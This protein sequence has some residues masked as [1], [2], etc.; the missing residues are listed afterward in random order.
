MLKALKSKCGNWLTYKLKSSKVKK[1]LYRIA[2]IAIVGFMALTNITIPTHAAMVTIAEETDFSD[3]QH[4]YAMT[5]PIEDGTRYSFYTGGW[6][7][8]KANGDP[9]FCIEPWK[10][11]SHGTTVSEKELRIM[12]SGSLSKTLSQIGYFG[13]WSTDRTRADYVTTQMMIWEARGWTVTQKPWYYDQKKAAIEEKIARSA[14]TLSFSGANETVKVNETVSFTDTNGVLSDYM[15]AAGYPNQNTAYTKDGVTLKWNGNT[16]YLT[17]TVN[18]SDTFELRVWN[19][20]EQYTGTPIVY[21]NGNVQLTSPLRKVYDP[22]RSTL[23]LNIQKFGKARIVKHD[24]ITGKVVKKAG[25]VYDI[26][27]ASDESLVSTVTSNEDGIAETGQIPFDQYYYVERTAPDKYLVNKERHYFTV[28]A[29][30]DDS[31]PLEVTASDIPVKGN[32]TIRKE[33]PV[34]GTRPQGDAKLDGAIYGLYADENIMDPSNDGTILY[35]KD[36]EVARRTIVNGCASVEDL[37]LGAYYWKEIEAPVG[38]N[39][40]P[41]KHPVNLRYKDQSTAIVQADTVSKDTVKEQAFQIIKLETPGHG[42]APTLGGAGFVYILKRYVEEY[43]LEEAIKIAKLNDGRI[44]PSEWGYMET[45]DDGYAISKLLPYGK[46]V[47]HESVVPKDHY[48]VDD[49]EVTINEHSPDQPQKFR[50]LID[51]TLET[52]LMIVKKDAESGETVPVSG[53]KFKVKCLTKTADFNAGDYVSYKS[54]WP[55][56]HVVDEW[57]T[58]E[59]G[60][61]MLEMSLK[62]GTYQIEE[63]DAKA[64]Y[65]LNQEPLIFT[66]TEGWSQIVGPDDET[67]IT[68]VEFANTSVKGQAKIDKQGELFKGYESTMTEYG[69][70]FTP[71]YERGMLPNVK[72]VLKAE[73]DIVGVDGTVWYTAG[74]LIETLITDGENITVSSLLPLGSEDHNLYSLRE[75]ETEEGYALDDTV[76]YFR[77]DYVDQN[78]PVVSPT[79]VNEN[80]DPIVFSGT[81][82]NDKQTGLAIANKEL[83]ESETNDT[84][85]AYKNVVFGL[86]TDDVDGL[87]TGSLVGI[88]TVNEDKKVEISM[89]REGSYYMQELKTDPLY[90]LDT[91]KYPLTFAYNGDKIQ[92]ITVNEGKPIVNRLKRATIEII[93]YTEEDLYYS[94]AEQTKLAELGDMSDYMR[95][96]LLEDER[97]YIAFV[98]FE[99]ATDKEFK[100]IIRTGETDVTGR[101]VFDDLEL[102]TFYVREKKS[103]DFYE[104]TDE[105]FEVT[106]ERHGQ[107]ETV[108]VKNDLIT[109]YVDVKKVD[110]YDHD[111]VL[112]FAGF[113]MYADQ[114]CTQE[115]STIKTGID[116]IAH[117][118]V[119]FGMTVYIKESEAPVGYK[120]SDEVIEITIDEDWIKGNKETRMIIYPNQPLPSETVNTGNSTSPWAYM[121]MFTMSGAA[122]LVLY[123]RRKE[124]AK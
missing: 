115:L 56:Y 15:K 90:Q 12:V 74:E 29:E 86:Y 94:K 1:P 89:S 54:W 21:Y 28:A 58:T 30:N 113:I 110:Y 81:I 96:D 112:P 72:F 18:A 55:V 36:E 99:L 120:L 61:V 98:E 66:I 51:E 67:L 73:T 63:V 27:K 64:P 57:E 83:E 37:P 48:P 33:D 80:G 104:I 124:E 71:V 95:N 111:R 44:L 19:I 43:G 92:T 8:L 3:T 9:V 68:V 10:E 47:V 23:T 40:D 42:E 97:K 118:E 75:V 123:K 25:I 39:L 122:L 117:F 101:L 108:E 65:L 52:K 116:G 87:E 6:F 5:G 103:A 7:Q 78:T 49:F 46:Y 70:L 77:F 107:F 45:D 60:S 91:R 26:Y 109:S 11:V 79:W 114:E 106:L 102:G 119:K 35:K 24:E 31:N 16:L 62:A 2:M 93:K 85:E 84:S 76:Y 20:A 50:F 38:Y 13:Y 53:M 100:N 4:A 41:D 121:G 105:I 32:S 17:P 14:R 88:G 82:E 69:E 22:A 59:D 34:S